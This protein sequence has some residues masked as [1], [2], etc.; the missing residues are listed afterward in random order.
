[1][2]R[3]VGGLLNSKGIIGL[4]SESFNGNFSDLSQWKYAGIYRYNI[5][6]ERTGVIDGPYGEENVYGALEVLL[7]ANYGASTNIIVQKFYSA[8][9][10]TIK[11]RTCK[12]LAKTEHTHPLRTA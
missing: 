3:V 11:I 6:T 10:G 4:F 5:N 9:Y 2:K 1:M 8:T 7:R 12:C